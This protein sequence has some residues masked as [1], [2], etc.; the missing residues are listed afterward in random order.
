MCDTTQPGCGG[1]CCGS[2]LDGTIA[3]G[4]EADLFTFTGTAGQVVTIQLAETSGFTPVSQ[5]PFATVF[6]PTGVALQ[7]FG[8]SQPT[9]T[10]PASGTYVIKVT[11]NDLT[12]TGSYGLGIECVI[13]PSPD[14]V[15]LSCGSR[16]DGTIAAGAEADLFTFTGT[17]GQV[18]TIQLAETSGFTPVS[19]FPFATVFSPTGVALQSFGPSQPTLTLPASGTYVIKVTANNLVATGAYELGLDCN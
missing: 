3:A 18:V 2:R 11:A 16:L 13:P 9:L 4:A 8:P 5:F 15:A 7:S 14:A 6:S 10:L 12:S 17:A 1:L 19:Q